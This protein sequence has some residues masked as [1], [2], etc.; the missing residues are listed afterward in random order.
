MTKILVVDDDEDILEMMELVLNAYEFAPVCI[1]KG[2]DVADTV[3][4]VKPA[5]ILMDIYLGK[6]D[7][8]TICH[9]LKKSPAFSQ[10]PVIL[11]S[12]G[13]ISSESIKESCADAF[14]IKPFNVAELIHRIRQFI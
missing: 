4:K 11:Y 12:A 3:E 13:H 6:Q 14:V 9:S 10:I 7:G 5:L 2:I 8:R 1:A